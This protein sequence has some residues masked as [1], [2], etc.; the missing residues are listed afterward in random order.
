MSMHWT[1]DDPSTCEH[2]RPRATCSQC[3]D[4]DLASSNAVLIGIILVV[5]WA[6]SYGAPTAWDQQ[7][8]A[9]MRS[10]RPAIDQLRGVLAASPDQ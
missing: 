7:H 1:S 4:H 2:R 9:D 10:A 5:L 6:L 3:L 8:D